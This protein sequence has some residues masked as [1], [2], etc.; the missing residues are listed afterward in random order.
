[1][2]RVLV[3]EDSMTARAMLVRLLE[4]APGI[5]VDGGRVWLPR[6][7]HGWHAPP[8]GGGIMIKQVGRRHT[9]E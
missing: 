5:E 7:S 6:S 2:I 4:E 3:V 9:Y 8:T 1:M